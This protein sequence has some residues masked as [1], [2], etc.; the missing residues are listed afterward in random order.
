MAVGQR[1]IV[2]GR[3]TV[4]L[5]HL[6]KSE[7]KVRPRIKGDHGDRGSWPLAQPTNNVR[8]GAVQLPSTYPVECR[9]VG[10]QLSTKFDWLRRRFI[11]SDLVVQITQAVLG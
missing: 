6:G 7:P 4:L 9:S 11:Q 8:D 1:V 3:W 2:V 5:E 10:V